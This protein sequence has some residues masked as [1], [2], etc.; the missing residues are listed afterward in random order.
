MKRANVT[1]LL[2]AGLCCWQVQPAA[3][4]EDEQFKGGIGVGVM[5]INRS[6]NLDPDGS[7]ASIDSLDQAADSE[8]TIIPL[9]APFMT[10]DVGSTGGLIMKFFIKPPIEEAGGMVVNLGGAYFLKTGG[11]IELNALAAP[12]EEVWENPYLVGERR[13][14]TDN[15][16]YGLHLAW[17][18]VNG[19]GLSVHGVYLLDEVDTDRIGRLEPELARDGTIYALAVDYK[20]PLSET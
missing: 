1:A 9:V 19:S 14:T 18:E 12:F 17:K 20:I 10:Y 8:L 13:S 6:D 5:A 7:D 3:A 2:L 15:P 16:R 4:Q 11:S